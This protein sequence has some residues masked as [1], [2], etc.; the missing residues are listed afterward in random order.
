MWDVYESEVE[1]QLEQF[2]GKYGCKCSCPQQAHG[3]TNQ[4]L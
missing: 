1:M 3:E 4:S 2:E